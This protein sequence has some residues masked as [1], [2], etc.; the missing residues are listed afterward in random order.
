MAT[1]PLLASDVRA[2]PAPPA[3]AA[4]RRRPS[5]SFLAI[6]TFSTLLCGVSLRN[7]WGHHAQVAYFVACYVLMIALAISL[8]C[9]VHSPHGS[10]AATYS[11]LIFC[12][13]SL[14]CITF[15]SICQAYLF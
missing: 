10:A 3:Q 12:L 14:A 7:Y 6:V 15:A 9:A 1:S 2:V 5:F 13:T 4:T 8:D 11:S